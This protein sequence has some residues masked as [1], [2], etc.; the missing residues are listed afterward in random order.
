MDYVDAV[1]QGRPLVKQ[2]IMGGGKTTVVGPMLS[3]ILGDGQTLVVQTMPPALLE[4]TKATLRATFSSIVRKRVFTLQF[5]RG[6]DISWATLEK[7]QAATKNRGVVMCT[8]STIK[9]LQLKL[10]EKMHTLRDPKRKQHPSM[11]HDVRALAQTLKIFDRGCL[12]MDEVDLLLHPL[13]AELNFPIGDKH[14]LDL[15][16]ERWTCAI[17]CL[18]AVFFVER[19]KMAVPFQASGRAH[20]ILAEL[21]NVIEA[22]YEQK[23]LQSSPHLTLLNPEWY[24]TTMRPVMARWQMLWLEANHVGGLAS[25]EIVGY[26]MSDGE[27]LVDHAWSAE[28]KEESA[29]REAALAARQATSSAAPPEAPQTEEER[30]KQ[31]AA[32]ALQRLHVHVERLTRTFAVTVP[33]GLAEGASFDAHFYGNCIPLAVPAGLGPDRVFTL[34]LPSVPKPVPEVE[35]PSAASTGDADDAAAIEEVQ[36]LTITVTKEKV[37]DKVGIRMAGIDKPR[38]LAFNPGR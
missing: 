33:D 28:V 8:A 1:R 30:H 10:L 34:T 17:H 16:P 12:I 37:A 29:M 31:A 6:S 19:Q 7:L 25:E 38:V 27:Q 14:A 11:E 18:D 13:K 23:A 2:M 24:H 22:G 36:E 9:S 15:S 32:R 21:C 4:Q 20:A 3:L 26:L 35:A 5:D